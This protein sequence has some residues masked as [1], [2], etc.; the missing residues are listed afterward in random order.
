MMDQRH[1]MCAQRAASL[2]VWLHMVIACSMVL[3]FA[4]HDAAAASVALTADERAWIQEHPVV[5]VGVDPSFP[6]FEYTDGQGQHKGMSADYLQLLSSRLG[7]EFRVMAGFSWAEVVQKVRA[8]ELDLLA[9]VAETNRRKGFLAFTTP[10]LTIPSVIIVRNGQEDDAA[11]TSLA[12][13][14]GHTIAVAEGIYNF[15]RLRSDYPHIPLLITHTTGEALEAVA[16]GRADAVLENLATATRL[17]KDRG[18]TNLK[19]AGRSEYGVDS[20]SMGVRNDA[21]MLLTILNKGLATITPEEHA[22]VFARWSAIGQEVLPAPRDGPST[23]LRTVLIALGVALVLF[24]LWNLW[25]RRQVRSRG[26]AEQALRESEA[27][28]EMILTAT[29]D[30]LWRCSMESGACTFSQSWF[31]LFGYQAGDLPSRWGAFEYLIHPE[32]VQLLDDLR[33]GKSLDEEG[34]FRLDMRMRCADGGWLPVVTRGK[35]LEWNLD[36]TPRVLAGL[37]TDITARVRAETALRESEQRARALFDHSPVS[38]WDEDLSEL[39]TYL[40]GL[41]AQG[42]DDFRAYFEAHPQALRYAVSTIKV[43]RVNA[44]TCS[45]FEATTEAELLGKLHQVFCDDSYDSMLEEIVAYANGETSYSGESCHTTLTGKRLHTLVQVQFAKGSE[46]SWNQTL[47]SVQDI[48]AAKEA[49]ALRE[50]VDRITRHDLKSPLAAVIGMPKLLREDGNLTPQQLEALGMLEETG[51]RMLHMINL[52]LD[53]Y[54]MERGTYQY[55]PEPVDVAKVATSVVEQNRVVAEE[56]GLTIRLF[57]E[58]APMP[59][60]QGRSPSLE[61]ACYMAK[62]ESLLIYSMLGNLMQN[63]M[64]ASE[65]GGEVTVSIQRSAEWVV[66]S[67]HNPGAVPEAIREHLFEKYVTAKPGGTGLGAYSARRMAE[68]MQG[69][70]RLLTSETLGTTVTVRLP[71]V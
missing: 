4:W 41:R 47:V 43:R 40:E 25:L 29:G 28:V 46:E 62:G 65:P 3:L 60:Q 38:L 13:M 23:S 53:L 34:R 9:C 5:R 22:E 63:A 71:A 27:S 20:Y 32:D 50:D 70:I 48:T 66:M 68:T 36:R 15:D 59:L 11:P 16:M 10:Y 26:Q 35:V 8:K 52:S 51:W 44:M 69:D 6:P 21:P 57:C 7:L 56:R 33:Q 42:V 49:E 37:H 2:R 67:I 54:K 19:I 45:L 17:I 18:L 39:K 30:G 61:P 55:S 14:E 12:T 24:W 58:D 64:E 1:S 31:R